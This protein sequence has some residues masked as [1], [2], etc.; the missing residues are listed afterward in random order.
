MTVK[1]HQ[2]SLKESFSDCQDMFIND[3]PSFFQLLE[4]HF[5]LDEFIP[6]EFYTAFY[7]SIGRKRIFLLSGFLSGFLSAFILQKWVCGCKDPCS[8]AKRGPPTTYE[9][10]DF[11]L[12]PGI[13]RDSQ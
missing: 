10:L 7:Q 1:Y 13:Q 2:L 9:N 4:M 11:R 8:T 3:T 5:D 6:L 12:F